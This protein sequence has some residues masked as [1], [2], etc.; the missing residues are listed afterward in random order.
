[1]AEDSRFCP[2]CGND[3]EAPLTVSR[4]AFSTE[5][6]KQRP[7]G[8]TIL[9]VLQVLGGIFFFILG[10]LLLILAGFVGIAGFIS[11]VPDFPAFFGGAVLGIIGGVMLII[12]ILSFAVAYGYW[13]GF[14]WSW[15]IGM[16]ITAI[17]L[18]IGLLSLP[19]SI[20]GLV[21]NGII[22]YYLTR[23]RVKRWFGKEPVTVTV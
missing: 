14:G 19:G 12:G 13:N 6:I 17:G 5:P 18:I 4:S 9:A 21:I 1:M 20:I 15:T 22:I 2:N 8:V 7:S 11:D 3:S 23:P 10:F 16:V